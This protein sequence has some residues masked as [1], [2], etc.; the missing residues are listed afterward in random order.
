MHGPAVARLQELGDFL[1]FDYGPND[2]IFGSDT[3]KVV[4]SVQKK[5]GLVQDGICGPKTWSIMLAKANKVGGETLGRDVI[6]IRGA[7]P[8]P[9]NYARQR[10][11][12]D[13]VG[14]TLH[15]TGTDMPSNPRSWERLNAHIGVTQEGKISYVNDFTDMIW[16]AQGLSKNTIGIEIEGNFC[17]V[18]GDKKTL[19]KGGG[20]P[21]NLN[22]PMH[23]ALKK[24]FELVQAEFIKN[25]QSWMRIYAHRQAS[26]TRRGDP[27]SEIWQAVAMPWG[28]RL[29]LTEYD[30]GSDFCLKNGRRIPKRWNKERIARY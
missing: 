27:G 30:G 3:L 25:K 19:W 1:G 7:H 10:S 26:D 5:F 14:V 6:D 24:V 21:H 28:E 17:G 8:R 4:L 15:Q 13:I 2:G 22:L 11:F 20:G 12:S 18:K 16:H 9:K 29:G 23:L